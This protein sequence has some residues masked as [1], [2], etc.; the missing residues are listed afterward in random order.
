MEAVSERILCVE[1]DEQVSR[2]IVRL[3]RAAGHDCDVAA[4]AVS[5]RERLATDDFAVVLCDIGLPGESGLE[6]L[7]ELSRRSPDIATVMVTGQD[8]PDIADAAIELGAYGYVTKPF[9]ANAFRI[10]LSN[11]LHRRRLELER[12]EYEQLL[13]ETVA[14]RTAEL[15]RA[16]RET[17][18]RLG[19]A[20]DFH[21]GVTGAHVERV[22][23]YAGAIALELGIPEDRAELIR[24]ASPLHDV[25]KLAIGEQILAKPATL[26]DAERLIVQ[27][28][29]AA[30]HE[31]LSGSGNE[32]LD[33]AATIAWCH[34]ERWDGDGYPRRLAGEE[35][36][37]EGRIV[38]VADVF[39]ALTSDR[40]YRGAL[41]E[42]EALD[43]VQGASGTAFDP[44]VVEAF[45]TTS[46]SGRDDSL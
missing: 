36:P 20:I 29:A 19:R 13:E 7:S 34:H 17:V 28:H 21:D 35:I 6:L 18:E 15:R 38:A 41:S 33:L 2:L 5:A 22:A 30:G 16:Y 24:L 44:R 23:S 11:A 9:H 26:T 43:Y 8:A 10:D 31:L 12:R 25:G 45:L 14:R 40:P 42:D 46:S 32:L 4:D 1:D 39:D 37:I 3:V 27:Q